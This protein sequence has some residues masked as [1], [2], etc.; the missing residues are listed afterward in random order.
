MP[1]EKEKISD[2]I[3]R[4]MD[5]SGY[6]ESELGKKLGL[7]GRGMVAQYK[8]GDWDNKIGTRQRKHLNK[9][10]ELESEWTAIKLNMIKG[11]I[12]ETI[13]EQNRKIAR[14]ETDV[15]FLKAMLMQLQKPAT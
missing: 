7:K 4:V 13:A 6:S 8:S 14:L 15:D 5:L 10:T 9:L 12:S 3:K 11:N 1:Q 2:L